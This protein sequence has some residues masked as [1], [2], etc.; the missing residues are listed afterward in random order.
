LKGLQHKQIESIGLL[1][2]IKIYDPE[3][4]S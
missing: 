3:L 1:K 4:G 2:K